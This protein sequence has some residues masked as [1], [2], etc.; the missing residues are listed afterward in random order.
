M[1]PK[2]DQTYLDK[3]GRGGW[4]VIGREPETKSVSSRDENNQV[5][6]T[7]QPT[8]NI[9][10]TIS[11][12]QGHNQQM[13]VAGSIPAANA[14]SVVKPPADLPANT[15]AGSPVT[16]WDRLDKNGAVIPPGDTTTPAVA[17]RDPKAPAGSQ[18][19]TL[20]GGSELGDPSTWTPIRRDPTDPTSE[21][22]GLYDPQ[23]KKVAA[24]VSAPP[25]AKP[26]GVYTNIIDPNDPTGKRVIGMV[27]TGDKSVHQVATAP[28][29]NQIVT[30]PTAIY[31]LDKT[32]GAVVNKQDIADNVNKQAVTVGGKVYTFDPK[33]GTFTLPDNIQAAATVGNTSSIKDLIWYD[34]QGN[35]VGRQSNPNYGKAPVTAPTPNT[36]APMIQVPESQVT[37]GGDPSKLVWIPNQGQVTASDALKAV[38]QHLSGQ[39]INGS[40]S[41]DEA[42]TIIDASNAKMTNDINQQNADTQRMTSVGTAAGDVLRN[43]ATNAQTGAGMLNQRVQTAT[44]ALN[45]LVNA[46]AGSKMTS[47][48]G[49]VGQ[50]LV[51]GLTDWTAQLGGGQATYDAAARMVQAADPKISGD[52]SLAQSATQTLA[53]M[54]QQYQ[55]QTGQPHPLVAA[56]QAAQQSAAGGGLTAPTTVP[57]VAAGPNL[58]NPQASTAALNAAGFQDTPQGRAAAQAAN[59]SLLQT[60]TPMAA[61]VQSFQAPVTTTPIAPVIATPPP[62]MLS[63][64][65]TPGVP[66]PPGFVAP[67]MPIPA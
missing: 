65:G 16:Q 61:P 39:V 60:P 1:D 17:I 3:V 24:S 2:D 30:T 44:G 63:A 34:D 54:F 49:G 62:Q 52:P 9:V 28:D 64:Y 47:I 43:T 38:A 37:P 8:G 25:N 45:S 6:T 56:T 53:S 31:T 40:M 42:K 50:G 33:D 5:V 46:A 55:Q 26:T 57:A 27:D 10:W 22:V 51:Q 23:S 67:L 59:P 66:P 18:P 35:E 58:Y 4:T 21:V 36:V 13:T 41:V 15:Q 14:D 48:P 12:G 19:Y 29:N 11:D 32:T 20:Q 7:E